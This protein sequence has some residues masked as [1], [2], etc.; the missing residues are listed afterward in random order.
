MPEFKK[1]STQGLFTQYQTKLRQFDRDLLVLL[2]DVFT[3]LI[4]I[5][6]GGTNFDDNF[7]G[8]TLT[9]TSNTTPNTQDTIAHGLSKAPSRFIVLS[10]NKGGVVYQSAT[11]DAVN[12]YL[13]N[14]VASVATTIFVF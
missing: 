8:T 14:T 1:I 12:V 5:L 2:E 3:N 9:Y 6:N 11:F 13:K 10:I 4:N 7:E